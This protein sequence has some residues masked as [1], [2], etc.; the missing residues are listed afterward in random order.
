LKI[1]DLNTVLSDW[2][3]AAITAW[4]AW[5]LFRQALPL[6]DRAMR[7]W[8][9]ALGAVTASAALVGIWRGF[10]ATIDPSV[11]P[12]LW[13]G[14]MIL[15]ST[16]SLLFLLS[17]LRVYASG[18][19]LDTL[20]A[21]AVAK[22]ALFA[23]CVA[24]RDDFRIVVYDSALTMIV[25]IALGAWGAWARRIRSAPWILAG[26]LVSML[27]AF[28]QEGRIS[29]HR[30]LNYNELW[31]ICEMGA[32]YLLFRGGLLLREHEAA[33]PHFDATQPSPI[34]GKE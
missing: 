5:R 19:M 15:A 21:L 23:I 30:Q 22:F 6:R 18:R 27:G 17:T 25:M 7:L 26:V 29:I 14:A 20:A 12:L 31:H 3:L 2:L 33:A 24:V 10:S 34:A 13:T 11:A 8:V 9:G 1:T 32:M 16:A 28:F 4:L